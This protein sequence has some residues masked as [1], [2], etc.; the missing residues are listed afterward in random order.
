MTKPDYFGYDAEV[1]GATKKRFEVSSY[2][3][4]GLA[5]IGVLLW[6]LSLDENSLT[7]AG[8]LVPLAVSAVG[9][10]VAA[11]IG[12]LAARSF[13]TRVADHVRAFVDSI[14][15][16][17]W[18]LLALLLIGLFIGE[19]AVSLAGAL[20]GVVVATAG[21]IAIITSPINAI[22]NQAPNVAD[23]IDEVRGL[24]S[25]A[26][27]LGGRSVWSVIAIAVDLAFRAGALVLLWS[28]PVWAVPLVVVIVTD[29]WLSARGLVKHS[30]PLWLLPSV[31]VAATVA[32]AAVL[33]L[34]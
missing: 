7:T 19:S 15:V 32:T 34:A 21:P 8:F 30:I 28:S 10:F 17:L 27:L 26:T 20:L 4:V 1:L 2:G 13:R 24:P 12:S 14:C 31:I 25:W 3:V 29:A 11:L 33:S 16:N 9:G 6:A 22:L 5:A 23:A 18:V